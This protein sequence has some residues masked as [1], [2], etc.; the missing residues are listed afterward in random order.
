MT[1]KYEYLE[2]WLEPADYVKHGQL[3]EFLAV[4]AP[5]ITDPH[6][7]GHVKVNLQYQEWVSAVKSQLQYRLI[8][9]RTNLF[10]EEARL[11]EDLRQEK[12]RTSEERAAALHG[13]SKYC[14]LWSRVEEVKLVVERLVTLEWILRS[15]I[16]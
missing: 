12:I 6:R 1:H 5:P 15:S 16:K 13:N 4:P 7:P 9:M 14:D 2:A 3:V 8:L 10:A 11:R